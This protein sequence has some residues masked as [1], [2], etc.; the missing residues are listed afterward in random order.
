MAAELSS[1]K[2]Q[3]YKLLSLESSLSEIS[4]LFVEDGEV[5]HD[6]QKV[7]LEALKDGST[8]VSSGTSMFSAKPTVRKEA[9]HLP[10][11]VGDPK[12]CF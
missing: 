3:F 10:D 9:A 11:F 2:K 6:A 1:L 7:V 8:A 12:F 4:E 5:F